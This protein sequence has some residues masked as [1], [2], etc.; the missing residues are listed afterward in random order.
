MLQI[1]DI[2]VPQMVDQLVATL[3]HLD[4][5]IPE[6]VI[7]VPKISSSSRCSRTV[8][9][10]SQ[11]AEQLVEVPTVVSFSQTAEQIIDIPV[12]R[13]RGGR[14]GLQ[15]FPPGQVSSQR[16]AEQVVDISAFFPGCQPHPQSRVMRRF[17]GFLRTFHRFQKS[18]QSSGRS[19]ARVAR[20][21]EL[22]V[23]GGL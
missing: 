10:V 16:T 13:T 20:A 6:Q 18:A 5:P 7:A 3:L 4:S 9:R 23:A 12:P 8:L 21:L 14:G 11:T 1:L 19:S 2:P 22:M 17:N 15:G